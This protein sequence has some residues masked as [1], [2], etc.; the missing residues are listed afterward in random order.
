MSIKDLFKAEEYAT[1][2]TATDMQ[3]VVSYV[4]G[5]SAFILQVCIQGSNKATYIDVMLSSGLQIQIHSW[6]TTSW[7]V[8]IIFITNTL[9]SPN[10]TVAVFGFF[11]LFKNL[12]LLSSLFPISF[13]LLGIQQLF[14]IIAISYFTSSRSAR[15]FNW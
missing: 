4:F 14:Y 9:P 1:A 11:S 12:F 5:L 8:Y 13:P 2:H 10:T 15:I 3:C 7:Y 6:K